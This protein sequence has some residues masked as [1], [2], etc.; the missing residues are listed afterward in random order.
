MLALK[1]LQHNEHLL[2]VE[3]HYES[4]IVV[5]PTTLFAPSGYHVSR[6]PDSTNTENDQDNDEKAKAGD[7]E[8][9]MEAQS[10]KIAQGQKRKEIRELIRRVLNRK[11]KKEKHTHTK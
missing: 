9:R 2:M 1:L 5:L 11:R 10:E 8:E 7:D 6:I 4:A 3:F